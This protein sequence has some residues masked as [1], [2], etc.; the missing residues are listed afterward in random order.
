M[1]NKATLNRVKEMEKALREDSQ[2]Q[3]E[4]LRARQEANK[5]KREENARKTE[6]VQ[7]VSF[8]FKLLISF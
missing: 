4:E 1:E 7:L 8:S 6:I 2:R 5:K 3:R